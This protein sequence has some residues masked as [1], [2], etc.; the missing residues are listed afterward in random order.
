MLNSISEMTSL[1]IE[2][3]LLALDQKVRAYTFSVLNSVDKDEKE[4]SKLTGRR[5]EILMGKARD[6]LRKRQSVDKTVT[7]DL[8]EDSLTC[9]SKLSHLGAQVKSKLK[10]IR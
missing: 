7:A 1:E 5:K 6:V 3:V 4:L 2:D 10:E 8:V 9:M